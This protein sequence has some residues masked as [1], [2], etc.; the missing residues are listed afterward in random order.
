MGIQFTTGSANDVAP[1]RNFLAA[2]YSPGYVLSRSEPFLQ[3]QFATVPSDR[4]SGID[5][6][7]AVV[8]GV[9]AGCLG[10][11]PVELTVGD[12][13]VRAAWAA[14]WMVDDHYRRLGLGPLLIR[15][16]CRDFDVALA[17]GGN[18]DAHALLPRMGWTDFGMLRRHVAVLDPINAAQ[19]GDVSGLQPPAPVTGSALVD[20]VDEVPD[21]ATALWDTFSRDL[22]GTRR[23]ADYLR[24]RY[25]SHPLFDYRI[26][27]LRHGTALAGLGVY[28]LESVRDAGITVARIVELIA[29]AD[30][31]A[32]LAGAMTADAIAEGAVF[33]D[34]F[35]PLQRLIAPLS[36]AGFSHEASDRFPMLFQPIDRSRTGVLFMADLRKCPRA[37][38]QMDWY[39][40]T[41]DGDQDRPN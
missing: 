29:T 10:Y 13:T 20:L 33:A 4:R 7:L 14:N 30:D 28:R 24:W 2:M 35:C 27:T 40:T 22:A 31:A 6:K 12:T 41:A 36:A 3:W 1:L 9:I 5:M 19:L 26:F 38:A 37:A 32:A 15:E 16:L 11:I 25:Q 18:Q 8:D 17:L 34:F 23:S 39:A 21:D